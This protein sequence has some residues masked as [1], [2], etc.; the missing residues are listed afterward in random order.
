MGSLGNGLS[1]EKGRMSFKFEICNNSGSTFEMSK[2]G[3][4][5]ISCFGWTI[6]FDAAVWSTSASAI[7]QGVSQPDIV[8]RCDVDVRV[9]D[10]ESEEKFSKID[11]EARF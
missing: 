4:R 1:S 7:A 11:R 3:L 9:G 6:I 10:E 5:W 2:S 8:V